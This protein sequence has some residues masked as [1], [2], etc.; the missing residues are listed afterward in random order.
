M[1]IVCSCSSSSSE[2]E[3][4]SVSSQTEG[5]VTII[6]VGNPAYPSNV[7][8]VRQ[9]QPNSTRSSQ[10]S[11]SKSSRYV[12]STAKW[13]LRKKAFLP[14]VAEFE[15][16]MYIYSFSHSLNPFHFMSLLISQSVK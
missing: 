11:L 16:Y 3:T 13:A 9:Q 10:Q 7:V 5:T 8:G 4:R 12:H 15:I 6:T 14:S 1:E 2:K